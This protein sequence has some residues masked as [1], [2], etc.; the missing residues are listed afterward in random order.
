MMESRVAQL[1]A[2]NAALRKQLEAMTRA[3]NLGG[4]DV[5]HQA[6]NLPML[7]PSSLLCG[8]YFLCCNGVVVYAGQSIN[9]AARVSAHISERA[10]EFD[11]VW[12]IPYEQWRL[13]AAESHWIAAIRPRYNC[14]AQARLRRKLP[15]WR[16]VRRE[17]V[18]AVH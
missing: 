15:A 8:V 2:E 3:N 7:A 9:V 1:E 5:P 11:S 17:V 13:G 14:E 18:T 16:G 6:I 10:K 12:F 4:I